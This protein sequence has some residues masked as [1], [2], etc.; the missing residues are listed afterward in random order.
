MDPRHASSFPEGFF[1]RGDE[2]DDADFY[3]FD[4]FV[5]HIDDG[6]IGA[7]GELYAEL[8][9]AAPG[10][11]PVLDICS[12][13]ISHFP[14]R[15]DRLVVT[16]MNA[17]EL[18]ANEMADEWHVQD[19]NVDPALAHD[20]AAFAAVTCAVSVD[21]HPTARRLCRGCS[22]AATGRGVRVYVLESMLPDEGDPGLA[23]ER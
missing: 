16:G 19:L 21:Y 23:R 4:R 15:P 14:T 5:T 7:I 3:A 12:S 22:F 1:V 13:W 6:A 8:Q 2:T 9:L 18:A 10:S 17:N 11:G 20:D